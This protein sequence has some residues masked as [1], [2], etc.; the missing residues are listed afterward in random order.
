MRRPSLT[1]GPLAERLKAWLRSDPARFEAYSRVRRVPSR[2]RQG[3]RRLP[4]TTLKAGRRAWDALYWLPYRA[5]PSAWSGSAYGRLAATGFPPAPVPGW[6]RAVVAR[7]ARAQFL[8]LGSYTP[9]RHSEAAHLA[10]RT[11][12]LV[13]AQEIAYAAPRVFGAPPPGWPAPWPDLRVPMH[14]VIAAEWSDALVV[15]RFDAVLTGSHAIVGDLWQPETER[16][17]DEVRLYARR[18]GPR[19]AY[20][21]KR[22]PARAIERAVV[23]VGGP[24]VNWAHWTTE[25]LPRVALA[26]TLD[27]YRDWPLVVDEG[28]H[29]NILASLQLVARQRELVPLPEGV[30][31]RAGRALTIGAPGY[32][33][34]EYRY[35][36]AAGPPRFRR[37]HTAFSPAALDLVRQRAWAATAAQPRRGRLIY[38]TRPKGSMRPFIGGEDVERYFAGQGFELV[39]TAGMGAAEQV[40]LFAQARC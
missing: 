9:V 30:A 32:T 11:T 16:T 21:R 40:L 17:F 26:D 35:D 15:G 1:S 20:L 8:P 22:E 7:I 13:P 38:V 10:Q 12:E 5:R 14:P 19:I 4:N 3:M 23:V 33:A 39:D 27:E 24:T 6:M 31:L 34:Y 29:P 28:L 37:E 18:E 25:Y 36:P 2:M